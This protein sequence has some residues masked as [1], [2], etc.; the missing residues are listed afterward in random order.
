MKSKKLQLKNKEA[1]MCDE[2]GIRRHFQNKRMEPLKT[3]LNKQNK[4]HGGR[5]RGEMRKGGLEVQEIEV[6][7]YQKQ[8]SGPSEVQ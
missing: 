1:K 8:P 3:C 5:K 2:S 7:V 4:R 6:N